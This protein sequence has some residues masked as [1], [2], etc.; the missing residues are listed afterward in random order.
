MSY[1]LGAE[2]LNFGAFIAFMGV[3][4]A[5]L[6]HY[7]CAA[8]RGSCR[9][10]AAAAA[11][12]P[13]LRLPLV[14]PELAGAD[15][16][17]RV[18]GH[19]RRLRRLEDP[20]LPEADRVPRSERRERPMSAVSP[21]PTRVER[22]S[23]DH[24]P[25]CRALPKDS[26]GSASAPREGL[27]EGPLFIEELRSRRATRDPQSRLVVGAGVGGSGR[28]RRFPLAERREG[29]RGAHLRRWHGHAPRPRRPR[30]RRG[31]PQ[32]HL[33]RPRALGVARE[34][35]AGVAGPG[36]ARPRARQ[37]RD[38]P[39]LPAQARDRPRARVGEARVRARGLHG[40]AHPRRDR[41]DEHDAAGHRRRGD[42]DARLQLLRHDGGRPVVR[43][44]RAAALPGRPRRRGPD[45]RG[46]ERPRPHA[47]AE[48]GG[49]GT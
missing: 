18:A 35:A 19:R 39:P 46:R 31:R 26:N 12:F 48:L 2:L 25:S 37:P 15:R 16:G 30:S 23:P 13:D 27:G 1:E 49:H 11:R 47:R 8:P 28:C 43:R 22:G 42:P 4:L 34:A 40:R 45:R 24:D 10:S 7:W 6:L 17:L 21:S 3:N 36:R 14:E 5:A 44:C 38:L 41:G 33:L 29:R 20:G 9:Q 32:R